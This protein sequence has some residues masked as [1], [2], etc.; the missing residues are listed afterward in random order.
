MSSASQ[1]KRCFTNAD[2]WMKWNIFSALFLGLELPGSLP[3]HI[4]GHPTAH[5][6]V[7]HPWRTRKTRIFLQK[8]GGFLGAARVRLFPS[9]CQSQ[10]LLQG[11]IHKDFIQLLPVPWEFSLS[12]VLLK[13]KQQILHP[14]SRRGHWKGKVAPTAPP[15]LAHPGLGSSPSWQGKFHSKFLPNAKIL[16]ITW[17]LQVRTEPSLRQLQK[18]QHQPGNV[19]AFC[20]QKIPLLLELYKLILTFQ[21]S[22]ILFFSPSGKF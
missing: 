16:G 4:Q 2:S 21:N 20:C 8:C 14:S 3:P 12:L 10:G 13:G 9:T 11:H 17:Q 6:S 5:L 15:A 22:H 7:T 19:A 1:W 18:D